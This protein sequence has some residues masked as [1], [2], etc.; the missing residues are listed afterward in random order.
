MSLAGIGLVVFLLASFSW[1][2]R[3]GIYI[4]RIVSRYRSLLEQKS[5]PMTPDVISYLDATK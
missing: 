2:T 4:E 5:R 1:A 3:E